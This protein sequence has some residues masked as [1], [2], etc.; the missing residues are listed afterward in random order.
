MV[1]MVFIMEKDSKTLES[2]TYDSRELLC[3]DSGRSFMYMQKS[4][5]ESIAPCSRPWV[6][7]TGDKVKQYV[8]LV[9]D[10]LD[11]Y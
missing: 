9:I 7:L 5:G 6:R 8:I 2:S 10:H 1:E 11:S 4:K 3:G